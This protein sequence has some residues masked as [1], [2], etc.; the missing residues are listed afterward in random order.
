MNLGIF[1]S[2]GESFSQ[3]KQSG[4]DIR[5]I[6]LYLKNYAQNFKKIYV[7]SYANE[8]IKL[9]A[10]IVLVPN[11]TGLH[12]LIYALLLPKIHI[13][14]VNQC[15]VV[16]GFGLASSISSF[17]LAKPFIINWAYDYIS[18]V[19]LQKKIFY[20]PLY[21]IL[22][23]LAFW[24]AKKVFI[25]TRSKFARLNGKKFIYLQNGVDTKLF[26]PTVDH[27]KGLV[28]VG[29][30]EK[31]KNLHFLISAVS[32]LPERLRHV[33]LVGN[34]SLVEEL[35][36]FAKRRVKL[37]II[38]SVAHNKLPRL[39][40]KFSIFLLPSLQEGSPKVLIEAM[41]C[42]LV[43]VVTNFPTA[44]E[45]VSDGKD[46]FITDFNRENFASKIKLLLSDQAL[47]EKMSRQAVSK[48]R[49]DFD[50]EQ[51]IKKEMSI[52]KNV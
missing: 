36:T 31:Q 26:K 7:F 6:N 16:R 12:R 18:F 3:M 44:S 41:A 5:F 9:P 21:F 34:G 1:L 48:I 32:L 17:F 15:D 43:P 46:G 40:K 20:I 33:T 51:L 23:K 42:G 47:Y 27:Q 14:K 13:S 8:K 4:Q 2:P 10:N 19:K 45:V 28:F 30:L 25:A 52:L 29:R 39:L 11:T 35:M 49:K 50:Q 24:K 37:S 38:P 22:E